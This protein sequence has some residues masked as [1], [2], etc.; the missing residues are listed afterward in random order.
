MPVIL[1]KESER[2]WLQ[3]DLERDKIQSLLQPYNFDEMEAYPV[4]RLVNQLG[5][6][7]E[8]SEVMARKEYPDLPEI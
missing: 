5:L 6:N 1:S 4:P 8:N 2:T 3:N 7:T